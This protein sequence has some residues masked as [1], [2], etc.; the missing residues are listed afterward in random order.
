MPPERHEARLDRKKRVITLSIKA[1]DDDEE[2]AAIQNYSS[3]STQ[4]GTTLG[5]LL[6]A[7]MEG[8]DEPEADTDSVDVEVDDESDDSEQED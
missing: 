8:G 2:A 7:Q 3:S 6:K 1:K 4:V 5:D